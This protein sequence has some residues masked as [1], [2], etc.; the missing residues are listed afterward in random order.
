MNDEFMRLFD[1]E[2]ETC[3]KT[4]T[5]PDY[6]SIIKRC[7][8]VQNKWNYILAI[9]IT[10]FAE[11]LTFYYSFQVRGLINYV[12]SDDEDKATGFKQV[13][14]FMGCMFLSL[15]GRNRYIMLGTRLALMIRRTLVSFLFR[16]VIRLSMKSICITNSGKLISLISSDL[17]LV[18]KGLSTVPVLFA[19]PFILLVGMYLMQSVM[20]WPKTLIVYGLYVL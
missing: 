19:S 13:F 4:N 3:K 10:F 2:I 9:T 7:I 5:T 14:L 17:F 20:G 16:K 15:I 12:K 8:I 6:Y 1:A 11:S 18:E